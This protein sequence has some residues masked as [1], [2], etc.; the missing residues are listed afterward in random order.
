MNNFIKKYINL[1][2]LTKEEEYILIKNYKN[3]DIKSR[4]KIILYNIKSIYQYVKK[5]TYIYSISDLI[6][7]GII[8]IIK[9][10]DHF[11]LKSDVRFNTYSRHWIKQ[12]INLHIREFSAIM[13]Y[14]YSKQ[15][16]KHL[17]L[18]NQQIEEHDYDP[19][20]FNAVVIGNSTVEYDD[21]LNESSE[22]IENNYIFKEKEDLIRENIKKLN[23]YDQKIIN[24]VYYKDYTMVKTGSKLKISKQRVSAK[25]KKI[26]KELK[27]IIT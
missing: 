8:G 4:E 7:E 18:T 14:K 24:M 22:N 21:D 10:L 26:N 23:P 9:A 27:K 16:I 5:Y 19:Q 11:D 15:Y 20:Y 3:G 6:Q 25:I 17:K 2:N 12:C 13:S 1:P